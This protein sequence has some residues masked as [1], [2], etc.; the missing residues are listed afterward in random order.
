MVRFAFN[1]LIAFALIYGFISIKNLSNEVKL[2]HGQ[3][4]FIIKNLSG[5]IENIP[6]AQGRVRTEQVSLLKTLVEF[7]KFAKEHDVEYWLDYGTLLGAARHNGFIPW[8]DDVDIGMTEENLMKLKN[9]AQDPSYGISLEPQHGDQKQ[10]LWFFT[11]KFGSFD[12]FSHVFIS[13]NDFNDQSRY[14][15][16]MNF[17]KTFNRSYVKNKILD[18]FDQIKQSRP[19]DDLD[20]Y[21]VMT[22]V[23]RM[24][25]KDSPDDSYFNFTDVFPLKK[26]VFEGYEFFV[27]NNVDTFLKRR[28]GQNYNDLPNDFGYSY[29]LGCW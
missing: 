14:I 19:S 2:L 12:I 22:R 10:F 20:N 29:H 28:Y 23:T 11:N 4:K 24:S 18:R 27:P 8:D 5:G 15:Y 26:H 25:G 17:L 21:M 7:D 3:N 16:W 9:L 1:S 13:K 6:K